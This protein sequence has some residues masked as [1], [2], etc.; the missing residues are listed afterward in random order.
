MPYTFKVEQEPALLVFRVDGETRSVEECRWFAD[1]VLANAKE[2]GCTRI[3]LDERALDMEITS[4]DVY[5]LAEKYWPELLPEGLRIAAIHSEK[6]RAVGA[7]FETML[8]NRSINY[9]SHESE[10]EAR[11]WLAM[12]AAAEREDNRSAS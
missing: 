1:Q 7:S 9:K 10:E 4:H 5:T 3:L 8:R 11:V 12:H 6:N 2:A